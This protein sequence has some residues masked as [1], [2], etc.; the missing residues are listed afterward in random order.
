MR[1]VFLLL[2]ALTALPAHAQEPASPPA[3]VTE[4]VAPPAAVIEAVS[5]PV[6]VDRIVVEGLTRTHE[7]VVLR[8]LPFAPG[9][10]ISEETWNFSATRLWNATLFS[11]VTAHIGKVVQTGEV[12]ATFVLEETWTLNP[13]FSFAFG[14]DV[15][16][17]RL[18]AS[19]NNV[20]GRFVE[21]GVQYER[22][23]DY[24]GFQAWV[25]EPRFLGK[26]LDWVVVVDRL[27]RP[28]PD[29]ADR[30][31]RMG[32]EVNGLVWSDKLRLTGKIEVLYDQLLPLNGIDD[33][34]APHN[35]STLAEWGF[36]LGRVDT[37]RVR[38][39]GVSLELR[40]T[41]VATN[42]ATFGGYTQG[43]LEL[44][45]L[46]TLGDRWNLAARIQ[47]GIQGD[48]PEYLQF[49]LGGLN[50]VRGYLDNFARTRRYALLN[51]EARLVAFDSHWISIVGAAFVDTA[52]TQRPTG[53]VLPMLSSGAGVRFLLPWMVK[54]GL[55][56]DGAVPILANTCTRWG[57]FCPYLSVGVYQ[58]F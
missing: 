48:A 1:F 42:L 58:F 5:F 43:W 55:R 13:L 28:R 36:R 53:G 56:I 6:R 17:L 57:G 40:Q 26:R 31:L 27:V 21:I 4:S 7:S 49:Y 50:V 3:E 34:D 29:F 41:L 37:V 12:V 30:R 35:W 22:F 47:A 16:W 52:V 18:G 46:Q 51:A 25:R 39:Q 19:D 45:A 24:N 8:E 44:L 23:G 33:P 32:T 14:G 54:T 2:L 9:E 15:G 38:Q 20:A 11:R 10:T